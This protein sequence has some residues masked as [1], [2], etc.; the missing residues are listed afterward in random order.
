MTKLPRV[1]GWECI[2]ALAKV[3]FYYVR[4]VG[5]H[6]VLRRDEPFAQIVVPLHCE[7]HRGTLRDIIRDAG[8]TV[9]VFVGLL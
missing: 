1:S 3:D 7:L 8:L 6:V 4:Q 9:E 2:R 5:S